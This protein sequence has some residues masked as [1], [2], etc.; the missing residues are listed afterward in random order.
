MKNFKLSYLNLSLKFAIAYYLMTFSAWAQSDVGTLV[1]R[2]Q[3]GPSQIF[4]QVKVARCDMTGTTRQ[5]DWGKYLNLNQSEQLPVGSYIVGFE[6]SI[7]PGWVHITR[8]S[9]VS[10]DL[11]KLTVPTS[12]NRGSKKVRVF[13]DFDADIERKKLYF[14]QYYMS[15]P[16]FRLSQYGFGDLYLASPGQLD[17]TLRLNYDTCNKLNLKDPDIEDALEICVAAMETRGWRDMSVFFK[18]SGRDHMER[19]LQ[20]GQFLQNLVSEAGDRRQIVMRR[21]LVSAPMKVTDFVSVFPGQYRF[22]SEEPGASS[23]S[24]TAGPIFEK[25]D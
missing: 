23:V 12:V 8:G 19:E 17:V 14:V 13:R 20:K 22:L 10:L 9:Q 11:V 7:Y 18:F 15:R 16:L 24:V 1:V 5:C 4:S 6:N 25:F 2:G 3:A 21:H